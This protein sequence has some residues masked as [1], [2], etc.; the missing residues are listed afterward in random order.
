[1][2]GTLTPPPS[3][4]VTHRALI[5]S[6]LA[7]GRSVIRDPLISDDTEATERVLEQLGVGISRMDGAW[8]IAGDSLRKPEADLHCRESGTTLRLVTALCSLVQGECKLLAGPSLSKRPVGPLVDGLRQLG[9]D[10]ESTGGFPPV[11]VMGEGRLPGGEAALPG[12]VSSQF[13]SSILIAAP[14]GERDTTL[15]LTTR[16]E[17]RPYVELTMEVQRIFGVSVEASEGMEKFRIERQSYHPADVTV[18]RDW[19][20]AAFLL[21]AGALAGGVTVE[22]LNMGS[23][24]ADAAILGILDE[25]GATLVLRGGSIT[26]EKAPLSGIELDLSDSPDLFPVVASLCAAASGRSVLRGLRRLRLKESDRVAAMT[27]GLGQ[28]GVRCELVDDTLTIEGG[29]PKGCVIDPWGDHRIAMAFSILSLAAEGETTILDA[30][31]VNK[32]YPGF[33]GDLEALGVEIARDAD[34]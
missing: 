1:M 22:D 32:S 28:M 16:L 4:S 23:S 25:M 20:T 33:W 5:C 15:I 10:C 26:V 11:T 34:E 30:E 19:S 7:E 31:C 3:K 17:S 6:A 2:H 14:R 29:S 8:K 24:Q 18:E 27:G 9:A 13:V 21:G 12:D